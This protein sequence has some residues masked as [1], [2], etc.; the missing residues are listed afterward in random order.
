MVCRGAGC[1][2][3]LD[4]VNGDSTD[5]AVRSLSVSHGSKDQKLD[6]SGAIHDTHS[7]DAAQNHLPTPSHLQS[8]QCGHGQDDNRNILQQIH[9]S[10]KHVKQFLIPAK[11][12]GRGWSPSVG[13]WPTD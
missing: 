11:A 6:G 8:P 12:A 2:C 5:P 4:A 7:E 13:Y 10:D 3:Q 9:N 1:G